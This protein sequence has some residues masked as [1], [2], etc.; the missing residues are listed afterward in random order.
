MS[1][2][3]IFQQTQS[4]S[5]VEENAF[6]TLKGMEDSLDK[7]LNARTDAETS[8]KVFAKKIY[9]DNG[10]AKF[11]IRLANNGDLYN[12]LSIYGEERSR[13]FLDRVCK[14]GIKFREV[15]EKV[16]MLYVKFLNTK[17]MAWFNNAE[18]EVR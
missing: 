18:R 14:D 7:E 10:K 15:N 6:Y 12:P 13:T 16:F 5:P 11:Y 9:R 4:T 1:E 3:F 8:K 2:E 17:N